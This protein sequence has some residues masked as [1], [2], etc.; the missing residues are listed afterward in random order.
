[1]DLKEL[2]ALLRLLDGTDVAELEIEEEGRRVRI[3]RG[4][5]APPA[6]EAAPPAQAPVAA[7]VGVPR[8]SAPAEGAGLL[9]IE[10]PMVGTF[11]RAPA[12]DAEPYVREGDIVQKGSVVC[13]VE[14]MKLMNEIESEVRG[15]IVRIAV[16][17]GAPV[18]YG[19]PLFL[20]E[21][22]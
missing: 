2:K 19:Q 3:R 8:A 14:A 11:Y 12:P 6:G 18:E 17:N 21:P 9:R 5:A 13:I 22:V 1:M 16:E 4:G 7:A 10:A 20:L 15:R